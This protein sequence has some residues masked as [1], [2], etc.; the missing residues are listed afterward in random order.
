MEPYL[1]SLLCGFRNGYDAQHVLVRMLEKK[2]RSLD[3]GEDIGTILIDLT[4]AL[5]C[6]KH[7]L[8]LGKL[9]AY[10]FS[11]EALCLV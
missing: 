5:D 11:R 8:L 6:I 9:D 2:K 10:S 4:K 3:K 7:D 1:S